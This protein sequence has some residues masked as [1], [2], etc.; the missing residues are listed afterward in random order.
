MGWT[1]GQYLFRRYI[2]IMAWL[3]VGTF[4]LIF[5]IDFAEFSSR[6]SSLPAFTLPLSLAIIG[7]RVPM[8]MQQTVPF[9]ALLAT[10]VLLVNLNRRSELVIIRAAGISVWRF[11]LPLGI[12]AFLFGLLII[13]VAAFREVE[14]T[15][16]HRRDRR[17]P[18]KSKDHSKKES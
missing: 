12:S 4:A 10:M 3:F 2:V 17:K 15:Q 16:E 13:L 14:V 7:M 5:I 18:A 1:L 11:L 9:I 8:F 6:T